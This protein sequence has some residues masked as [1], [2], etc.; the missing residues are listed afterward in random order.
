MGGSKKYN[1]DGGFTVEEYES[2]EQTANGI[3]ILNKK[4]HSH[5]N[6]PTYS[7]TPNTMYAK[8]NSRNHLVDQVTVYGN[9]KDHRGKLKDIDTDHPHTNPDGKKSFKSTD[10]H[11]QRY[12]E[13]GVRSEY[14]EK[15]SKKERRLLMVARHG[16]RKRK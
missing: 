16:K 9:G 6:T 7:N 11:V 15:P 2:K 5:S 8:T 1:P 10:I 14:A 13:N 4:G 12:D 3:K